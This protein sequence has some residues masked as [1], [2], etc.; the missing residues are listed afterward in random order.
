VWNRLLRRQNLHV[1]HLRLP[2]WRH[3][4]QQ[5]VRRHAVEPDELRHLR[6]D[7]PE[8]PGVLDGSLRHE[9]RDGNDRLQWRVREH[10]EQRDELRRLRHGV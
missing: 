9:L 6:H 1:G 10:D 5:R 7:V 4:L 2:E 3:G 8:R